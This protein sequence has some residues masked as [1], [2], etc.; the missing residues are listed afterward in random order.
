MCAV[1][2][3]EANYKA[4]SA[5]LLLIQRNVFLKHLTGILCNSSISDLIL[6]GGGPPQMVALLRPPFVDRIVFGNYV[7]FQLGTGLL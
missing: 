4:Y 2:R 7:G 6:L 5:T 3:S 1:A